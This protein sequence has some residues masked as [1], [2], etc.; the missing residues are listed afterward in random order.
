MNTAQS[1][2]QYTTLNS[3]IHY[4]FET[5]ASTGDTT[6]FSIAPILIEGYAKGVKLPSGKSQDARGNEH[7]GYWVQI[8]LDGTSVYNQYIVKGDLRNS[9]NNPLQLVLREVD[10]CPAEGG[11]YKMIILCSE[12]YEDQSK[13]KS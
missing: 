5:D 3:K 8:Q 12:A 13:L 7:P 2:S 9:K 11:K 6:Y 4:P 10:Y 1:K